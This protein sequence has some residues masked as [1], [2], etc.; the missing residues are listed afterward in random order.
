M[1]IP[2]DIQKIKKEQYVKKKAVNQKSRLHCPAQIIQKHS[3][4]VIKL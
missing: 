3:D 1:K 2:E 4:D